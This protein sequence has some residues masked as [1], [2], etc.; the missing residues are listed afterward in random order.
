MQAQYCPL[1]IVSATAVNAIVSAELQKA[2][3]P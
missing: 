1:P 2:A 3:G